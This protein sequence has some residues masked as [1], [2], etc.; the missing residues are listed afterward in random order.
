[1]ATG[2]ITLFNQFKLDIGKKLLDLSADTI[3]LGIVTNGTVP[4]SATTDPRWGAGGSTNFSTN[5][6]P[7]GTAYTGPITLSSVTWTLVGGIA[8]FS[9]AI[10]TINQDAS[11]FTTA[12]YGIIYDDTDTGK[13]AVGFVDLGGPKSIQG[14][15]LTIDWNGATDNTVFTFS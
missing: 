8:T 14:G 4:T 10:V 7:T 11:G 12:Y 13:R 1:M 5:Q 6:V 9:A 3:K 15:S 2:D